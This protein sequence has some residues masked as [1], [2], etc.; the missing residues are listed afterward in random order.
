MDPTNLYE[1]FIKFKNQPFLFKIKNVV[2]KHII[3]IDL[4][5]TIFFFIV[6]GGIYLIS[7]DKIN[8]SSL[9]S[10]VQKVRKEA[11]PES[12]NRYFSESLETNFR[13]VIGFLPSWMVAQNIKVDT[14][15][16][17]QIIYFGIG[18]ND[19]GEV[20]M[21]NE[22]NEPTLEWQY[23]TSDYFT[24]LKNEAQES[25]TKMLVAFKM[26]DNESI[27]KLIS[28]STSTNRFTKYALDILKKY[29]L[30]G[31]NLDFE[32]FTDSNFPTVRYMTDFLQYVSTT[33][34]NE[35][36]KYLLSIDVNATVMLS[37]KAYDMVKI[38]ELVDQIIVMAYDYRT[39]S[40][41]V[42]GHVAP[43]DSELN[44]HSIKQSINSLVGRVPMD[45]VI[46]AVPF[47]GYEWETVNRKHKSIVVPNSGALATYKRVKELLGGRKDIVRHWD[48]KAMSPWLVY[49]QSGAIKQI[50]YEDEKSIRAKMEFIKSQ[51]LGGVAVW[52]VGYEGK[53]NDIWNVIANNK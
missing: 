8:D 13:H 9:I 49:E 38:G 15:A 23:F 52:A 18:V 33:L 7:A 20:I 42:A 30:D 51:N 34:K 24:R 44:E 11:L 26:F 16:M 5:T 1:A 43:L 41:L 48:E 21:F 46:L 22:K 32:Y 37:D 47:Y 12:T 25:K 53:Y 50:Y 14:K 3:A 35:N 36:P 40:S 45:K 39:P 27:D 31:I 10:P 19:N 28:N 2:K 17:T 6:F 4:I 29:E